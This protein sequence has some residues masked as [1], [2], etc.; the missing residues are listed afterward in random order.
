MNESVKTLRKQI[1]RQ[2]EEVKPGTVLLFDS[3]NEATR[4]TYTYAALYIANKWWL[5]GAANYYGTNAFTHQ[6]FVELVATK[7]I[8]NV[9]VATE[10]ESVK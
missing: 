6:R 7:E 9:R 2:P 8:H 5:T 4:V 1:K 3:R 10:F